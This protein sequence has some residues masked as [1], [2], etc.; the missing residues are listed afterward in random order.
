MLRLRS[1][2]PSAPTSLAAGRGR[3]EVSYCDPEDPL[4]RRFL[5]GT[6]ERLTGQPKLQRIYDDYMLR[7]D[8]EDN[9][10]QSAV[11]YLRLSIRYDADTL[12]AIPKT[13]PLIVIANHPFGVLDGIAAGYLTTRIRS[14]MK[15]M[16]HA[17]LGRAT[18]LRP[19]LIPIEFDGA[20]SALRSNVA[21]KRA[22][23]EH[24][25]DGGSLVIFPAGR[26]STARNVLGTA[27]DDPWKLFAG[28]L[29]E[30]SGATVVPVFFAGQNGMMFHLVSRF[31]EAMRE[32]LLLREVARRMG[33]EIVACIGTPLSSES[34]QGFANRQALLDYL[35][36]EVYAMGRVMLSGPQRGP[37]FREV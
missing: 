30:M 33:D 32:A 13:G 36:G 12:A 5:I 20:S 7:R 34:L 23:L 2:A 37:E 11:E 31:S 28:K 22:A 25:R 24:L 26:V 8:A 6:I 27:V 16:A 35:R 21:A 4:A 15:L 14:D 9:F 19:Y 3:R 29:I 1:D 18:A 17:A 10:W